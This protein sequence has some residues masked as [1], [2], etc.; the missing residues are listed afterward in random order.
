MPAVLP[1]GHNLSIPKILGIAAVLATQISGEL[2]GGLANTTNQGD[3]FV[4]AYFQGK[5]KTI[6]PG[7]H[8]LAAA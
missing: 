5:L 2:N 6:V 7:S 3:F 4:A 1:K 8:G